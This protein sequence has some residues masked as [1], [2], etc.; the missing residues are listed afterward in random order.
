[1]R[2][3]IV[4]GKLHVNGD[5]VAVDLLFDDFRQIADDEAEAGRGAPAVQTRP[6]RTPSGASAAIVTS[7]GHVLRIVLGLLRIRQRQHR[8]LEPERGAGSRCG[9]AQPRR[10]GRASRSRSP[11]AG[12]GRRRAHPLSCRAAR[13][14][15]RCTTP[16]ADWRERE[17]HHREHREH[18]ERK[19]EEFQA[20]V[21]TVGEQ[22]SLVA[23]SLCLLCVSPRVS[24]VS[25]FFSQQIAWMTRPLL[26]IFDRPAFGSDEL[27]LGVDAQQVADRRGQVFGA[28]RVVG[29]PLGAGV[30][31][32]R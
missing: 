22:T 11:C 21:P 13:R 7:A 5:R 15:G 9:V 24:A 18:R 27:V 23:L 3:L 28:V 6:R 19:R 4:T 10:R 26:T 16:P 31:S 29:R 12:T 25:S 2:P 32:C 30:G 8:P 14:P 20:V 1:M 17:I